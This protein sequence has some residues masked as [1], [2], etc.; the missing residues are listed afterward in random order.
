MPDADFRILRWYGD[1]DGPWSVAAPE[2]FR[3]GGYDGLVL[4]PGRSWTPDDLTLLHGLPGLRMFA[5]EQR[6]R[7]DTEAFTIDTLEELSLVTGAR[8]PVP[9]VVQPH[10]TRLTLTDRDGIDVAIRWPRLRDLQLGQWRAPDCQRLAGAKSLTGIRLDGRGQQATLHGIEDCADLETLE[11]QR[12]SVNGIDP[13]T[14]LSRLREVRLMTSKDRPHGGLDL[15]A[16]ASSRIER[17]WISHAVRLT[18]LATLGA[19][20][21]LSEV[22][23]IGCSFD[24]RD[25]AELRSLAPRAEVSIS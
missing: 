19:I 18:S 9:E 22:R 16:L 1:M 11:T 15:A 10:L 12:V 25:L 14:G 24:E 23:L 2:R 8:A 6:L 4:V 3:R 20:P 17:V 13:L 21:S 7:R 5:L